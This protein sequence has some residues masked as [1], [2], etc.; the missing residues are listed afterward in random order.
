MFD[1]FSSDVG[2][3][4]GRKRW[5]Y[6]H[7]IVLLYHELFNSP[8]ENYMPNENTA[9]R[10]TMLRVLLD[11]EFVEIKWD[12]E[13]TNLMSNDCVHFPRRELMTSPFKLPQSEKNVRNR[14]DSEPDMKRC[15]G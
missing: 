6:K 4:K 12:S 8:L 14:A 3:A 11:L 13:A 10:G 2:R 15:L 9:N 5:V 7:Y 1:I